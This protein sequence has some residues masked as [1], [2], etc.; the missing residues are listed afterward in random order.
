MN[1]PEDALWLPVVGYEGRYEVSATGL[2]RSVRRKEDRRNGSVGGRVL[3]Q[4]VTPAGRSRVSLGSGVAKRSY[5]VH[6]LVAIAFLGWPEPGFEVC[7]NDGNALN[8]HL[9]N[10]RWDTRKANMLDLIKHGANPNTRKT[11]CPQG[12]PYSGP[13][14]VITKRGRREC[15]ICRHESRVRYYRKRYRRSAA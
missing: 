3:R 6:R 15:R 11:H 14:L 9:G 10:L 13:N 2:V 5:F 8:N 12:H 1:A 7:H 4:H